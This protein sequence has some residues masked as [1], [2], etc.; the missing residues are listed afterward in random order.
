MLFKLTLLILFKVA[1]TLSESLFED[2]KPLYDFGLG[3][4]SYTYESQYKR[5]PVYNFGLGKR[6]DKNMYGFGLGKRDDIQN[7]DDEL[8]VEKRAKGYDFGLGKRF[9]VGNYNF[10]LGKK[11]MPQY[12]FGLGKRL[13]YY[14]FG[15][16]K[17]QGKLLK[18]TI[19]FYYRVSE[20]YNI[21]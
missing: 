1:V 17:R 15:L 21:N 14:N 20:M 3:K 11:A 10:G 7:A 19:L 8:D 16:G 13:G 5:L 12:S 2:E 18:F 4:R 6:A 9:P